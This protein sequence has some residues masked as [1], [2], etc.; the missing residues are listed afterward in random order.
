DLQ[1]PDSP[2]FDF[3]TDE[4]AELAA[5]LPDFGAPRDLAN[6]SEVTASYTEPIAGIVEQD[7]SEQDVEGDTTEQLDE[8]PESAIVPDI[9]EADEDLVGDDLALGGQEDKMPDALVA[10]LEAASR[11]A[12]RTAMAMADSEPDT[13]MSDL[14]EVVVFEAVTPPPE[15]LSQVTEPLESALI[16]DEPEAEREHVPDTER[17]T[18]LPAGI[19]VNLED[20]PQTG[21]EVE[22]ANE[23]ESELEFER[24][25]ESQSEPEVEPENQ[26]AHELEI[27]LENDPP[28]EI[29]IELENQFGNELGVELESEPDV[30][31]S[32]DFEA[33]AELETEL[34]DE[35][36]AGLEIE[37]EREPEFGVENELD[38]EAEA[39]FEPESEDEPESEFELEVASERPNN[40]LEVELEDLLAPGNES[41]IEQEGK[42]DDELEVENLEVAQEGQPDNEL[43]V[44]KLEAEELEV[45]EFE[46]EEL[47][48]E[49]DNMLEEPNRELEDDSESQ[50]DSELEVEIGQ[51]APEDKLEVASE[52]EPEVELDN[53]LMPED[54]F[55]IE[56]ENDPE[57]APDDSLEAEREGRPESELEVEDEALS[58]Y[59]QLDSLLEE[60]LPGSE[61]LPEE[62]ENTWSAL[63]EIL[64]EP[65]ESSFENDL[66]DL[67]GTVETVSSH[68]EDFDDD[69]DF[70]SAVSSTADLTEMLATPAGGSLDWDIESPSTLEDSTV[71][72]FP[73]TPRSFDHDLSELFPALSSPTDAASAQ[74]DTCATSDRPQQAAM[75]DEGDDDAIDPQP[76]EWFLGIDLGTT[77]LSAVLINKLS[78]QVYPLCW[79]T[80]G[81]DQGDRF[82]LPAVAPVVTGENGFLKTVEEDIGL[83]ALPQEGQLLRQIKP[84]IKIGIPHEESG[85]PLIQWSDQ[86]VLPLLSVQLAL[87]ELL[88]T[89]S[90]DALSCHAM[91]MKAPALRAALADLQGVMVGYPNN[92]PDTYSFNVREAVLAAGVVSRPDQ[93]LFVEEAIAALLS[94]L[95]NSQL[96]N[97]Q[98]D[99]QPGLYNCNWSGGTVVI[100]AGATLTESAIANLPAELDQLSYRDFAL[101]S[102][103]YAGDSI[104][105][106][107]VC[108]LLDRPV[109]GELGEPNAATGD[110]AEIW[111]SLGLHRL[112]LPQ[113]GEVDRL[114]RH[115]LRQRLND[116]DLGRQVLAAARQIK[117]ALQTE[118]Q[119][120]LSL[121]G[122]HWVI[123]SKDLESKIFLPYVQRI[124][125]QVSGLLSQSGLSDQAVKQVV[126]TGGSA[127][128]QAIASW[129]RQKFPN[130]TIIQ[131]TYTGEYSNSCSRVAYGL[132]N[133]CHYPL[134]LDA[135]RHQYNDYFLLSELLRILPD[136]PLP[137]GGILHLLAQRGVDTQ[138]CQSHILALIE[139]HLPPGL[140][141]S[142]GDR[143]LISAQSA[144]TA[145][146]EMLAEL[147]L[148]RKQGGQ[149]YVADP[150]QGVRLR[151]HLASLLATKAQTLAAPLA[152]EFVSE[153]V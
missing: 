117:L 52:N 45:G 77:G 44:G 40:G 41:E 74:S 104:D 149:I 53:Q 11:D 78:D 85:E 48:A 66:V 111:R 91:E 39:G 140:V 16:P 122:H 26:P 151:T 76:A 70:F 131:D 15:I 68:P 123:E 79:N 12:E 94:A 127:S 36:E 2:T 47:E 27:E 138:L 109:Q 144:E 135:N 4:A 119:Y 153:T 147:P 105:Q 69:L 55:E 1:R 5:V 30:K 142:E 150:Q 71:D 6:D 38:N 82:R 92:W 128:L 56:F 120:E 20:G 35:A 72:L 89:L 97:E 96:A 132:A 80:A 81:D 116:S 152:V 60:P 145:T 75:I 121:G 64:D 110:E 130:A 43:E 129:L 14:E 51:L 21:I 42:S 23:V 46:A 59:R 13:L 58:T 18:E 143:P 61:S 67:P 126:C 100:S 57:A 31:P 84:L 9:P 137:A 83:A 19:E 141:P 114:K 10:E 65:P 103:A 37:L 112:N 107:I 25:N 17:E 32:N 99:Q 33:E 113:A 88:K 3:Q 134:V 95:P 34:E 54:G 29:E 8:H 118:E 139:G 106:D 24:E 62:E 115:R 98:D 124:N 146:Y 136:Q 125:R 7:A 102:F 101:R 93:V 90:A 133:L 108:Q 50:L 49:Q 63:E 86:G 28:N 73:E 22:L 87:V 148:F